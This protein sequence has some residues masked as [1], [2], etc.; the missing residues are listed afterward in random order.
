LKLPVGFARYSIPVNGIKDARV[1]VNAKIPKEIKEITNF[2]WLRL[3]TAAT[4]KR[5]KQ[6]AINTV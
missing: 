4:P 5:N 3:T 1:A 6:I 2:V